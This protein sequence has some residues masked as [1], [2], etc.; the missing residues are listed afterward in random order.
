M[1]KIYAP[2]YIILAALT[3][4][5]YGCA[6]GNASDKKKDEAPAFPVFTLQQKDTVLQT[7]YVADVQAI[8]NVEVRTRVKGFIEKIFVDEGMAVKKGQLLFK[9]NDEEFRVMLSK[10]KAALSNAKAAA[11]ATEVELERIKILV[12]KNVV[13]KSEEDVALAKLNADKATI[14]EAQSAVQ[15]ANNHIAYTSLRAPFD[16]IIDRIPL[17]AGSLVEEGALL[18]NISDI[19]EVFAY[20][21]FPE[22]EYLRYERA[23][24]NATS[25]DD[26]QVKLVLSDGSK[27][28]F[29]GKIETVEGQIEQST[30][31]IDFRARFPNPNKLLRHG[32]S[33]KLFITT[34]MDSIIL[35]PQQAVFDIQDKSY[36]YTVDAANKLHMQAF[37]PITRLSSYYVVKDGLKPGDRILLE[38]AQNARDGMTIKPVAPP[39]NLLAMKTQDE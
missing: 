33:A 36:V 27:Y 23:R 22:N 15:S 37:V 29:P 26:E 20:F 17:K 28:K 21:S 34:G 3:I 31:S 30:G 38:G 1:R 24:R 13:A 7:G 25:K 4:F 35:V 32:A 19:S 2:V 12:G 18:T 9:I 8:K 10:A 39:K 14:E 5:I 6:G 16:G 11:R